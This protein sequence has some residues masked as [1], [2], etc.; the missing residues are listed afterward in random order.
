VAGKAPGGSSQLLAASGG[1][2]V[3]RLVCVVYQLLTLTMLLLL[4]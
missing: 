3:T 1:S 4:N 2:R